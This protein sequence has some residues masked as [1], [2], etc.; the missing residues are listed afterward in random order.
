MYRFIKMCTN[1]W[2]LLLSLPHYIILT[3][4]TSHHPIL[5]NTYKMDTRSDLPGILP[6]I[7]DT[8]TRYRA[9]QTLIPVLYTIK[10]TWKFILYREFFIWKFMCRWCF[11]TYFMRTSGIHWI[12]LWCT[13]SPC[14]CSCYTCCHILVVNFWS[15][16]RWQCI[17]T[18]APWAACSSSRCGGARVSGDQLDTWELF[19]QSLFIYLA[20]KFSLEE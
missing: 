9:V 11:V 3:W 1:F 16:C 6:F 14:I 19:Y 12:L 20:A 13:V 18:H 8:I 15:T 4:S 5:Q 7:Y 17:E 10:S 2:F